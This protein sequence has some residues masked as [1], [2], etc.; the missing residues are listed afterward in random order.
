MRRRGM[1]ILF[2]TT[3]AA[4]HFGPLIP[5]AHACRR[6][7]H[8]VIVAAAGSLAPHVERA[9][10]P[11]A[12]LRDPSLEALEPIWQRLRRMEP[13][14]AN[15]VVMREVFAGEH[16]GAALPGMLATMRAWQPDVVLRESCEFASLV[17]AE[18]L[19]IPHVHVGIFLATGSVLEWEPLVDPLERLRARAGLGPDPR[20]ERLWDEPYLT[21]TPRSLEDPGDIPPAGTRRFHDP[22]APAQPLPDWWGA[23]D[24]PL[25]YVSFGSVAAG[26]GFFP[27]LYR[28]AVDELADLPIRVLLTVGTDADPAELGPVPA[29]VRVERWVPQSAVTPHTAAMVGHGGSGSTLMAMAAG[30]PVALIPL[31]ADQ[32]VN[33]RRVAA[34]GAGIA[35]GP[36]AEGGDV[37]TL[38]AGTATDGIPALRGAVE[39]LLHEPGHRMAARRVAAEI[40]ALP[41]VDAVPE[42]LADLARD[43]A[44]AA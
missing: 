29:S 43:T 31:F 17:A 10:L 6:A 27:G 2:A 12:A 28:A 34:L 22:A 44:L 7:G 26:A 18:R 39:T 38:I 41:P 23:S 40:A 33:A 13:R 21:L 20:P 9:G 3:R 42:L 4:G 5:F 14:D 32:P 25:V 30:V 35:L 24:D 15:R 11:H 36:V 8:D 37:T 16:A 1:R 19:G